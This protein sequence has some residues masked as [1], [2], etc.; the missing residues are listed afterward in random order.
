MFCFYPN[1]DPV[2]EDPLQPILTQAPQPQPSS[3]DGGLHLSLV[4]DRQDDDEDEG[5]VDGEIQRAKRLTVHL[6]R[7]DSLTMNDEVLRD[8]TTIFRREIIERSGK[9]RQANAVVKLD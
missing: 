3:N 7:I 1:I 9:D 4:F 6:P 2:T 8:L 5:V